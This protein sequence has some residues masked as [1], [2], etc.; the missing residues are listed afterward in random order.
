MA[1]RGRV[2]AQT[3]PCYQCGKTAA[4]VPGDEEPWFEDEVGPVHAYVNPTGWQW[5]A[6]GH[7]LADFVCPQCADRSK[8]PGLTLIPGGAA[9]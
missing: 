6:A 8:R 7:D 2:N 3:I 1:E 4:M 9:A 5:I